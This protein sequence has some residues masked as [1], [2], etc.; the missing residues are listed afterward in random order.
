MTNYSFN[1]IYINNNNPIFFKY[2]PKINTIPNDLKGKNF[3]LENKKLYFSTLEIILFDDNENRKYIEYIS[4]RKT[5]YIKNFQYI[6]DIYFI[7]LS[8]NNFING[9]ILSFIKNKEN[10]FLRNLSYQDYEKIRNIC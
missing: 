9:I 7:K 4:N 3:I 2:Y 5:L 1:G 10:Y 6:D 8:E